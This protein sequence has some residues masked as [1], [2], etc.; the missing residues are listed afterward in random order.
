VLTTDGILNGVVY[1]N[2]VRLDDLRLYVCVCILVNSCVLSACIMVV[3]IMCLTTSGGLQLF[4][5]K[6][7]DCDPVSITA[8]SVFLH[9]RSSCIF[10]WHAFR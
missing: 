1:T 6:R 5:R 8:A 3:H 9:T 2:S 10:L 4:T 7:G